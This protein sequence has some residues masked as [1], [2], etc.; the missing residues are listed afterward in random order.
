MRLLLDILKRTDHGWDPI[1]GNLMLKLVLPTVAFD[2]AYAADGAR[3][4]FDM[5][6]T[7]MT[8]TTPM[9]GASG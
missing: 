8:T 9:R 5:T 1:I 2:A 6:M 3:P 4:G 7:I